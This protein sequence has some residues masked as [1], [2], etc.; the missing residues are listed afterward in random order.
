[1]QLELTFALQVGRPTDLISDADCRGLIR[2][3]GR[4]CKRWDDGFSPAAA[5][6]PEALFYELG[7]GNIW[8]AYAKLDYQV[9]A[10]V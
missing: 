7:N 5:A 8:N 3:A 2:A 4:S 1:M 9:N 6:L 10:T